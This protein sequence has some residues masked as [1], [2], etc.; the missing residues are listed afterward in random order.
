MRPMVHYPCEARWGRRQR[1]VCGLVLWRCPDW[2]ET[3]D[4][5]LTASKSLVGPYQPG[6]R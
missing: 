1:C 2:R 4:Q 6:S 5:Q 3:L